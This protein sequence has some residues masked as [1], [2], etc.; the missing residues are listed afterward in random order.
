MRKWEDHSIEDNVRYINQLLN[1]NLTMKVI[2]EDYY[3]VSE[4]VI[5][6]RLL[7]KGYKRSSEG[8]RLFV[9]FDEGKVNRNHIHT[10][11]KHIKKEINKLQNNYK[12]NELQNNYQSNF[13]IQK[14]SELI[15]LIEPIKE[16]L[17]KSELESNILDISVEELKVVKVENP[18]VRSFKISTETLTKWDNFTKENNIYSVMDLVNSALLEYIH[19][20][21]KNS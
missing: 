15:E 2:E 5:V 12:S 3:N 9:L 13:D 11:N 19:K 20:Y 10:K 17:K 4:R 21:S 18:K 7:R 6:K 8:Y 14:L 16:L 1:Q